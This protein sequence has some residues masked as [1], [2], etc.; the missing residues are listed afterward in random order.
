MSTIIVVMFHHICE[1]LRCIHKSE[2]KY[3]KRTSKLTRQDIINTH[4][5]TLVVYDPQS[6]L[7]VRVKKIITKDETRLN[8]AQLTMIPLNLNTIQPRL[9]QVWNFDEI[10]IDMNGTQ[11]K[12]ICTYNRC[13]TQQYGKHKQVSE[14]RFGSHS[15]FSPGQI[16]S[17]LAPSCR[18]PICRTER[19][20]DVRYPKQLDFIC[21]NKQ[22]HGQ[23]RLM[24]GNKLLF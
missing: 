9:S 24:E 23:R 10:V 1:M 16:G 4:I 19:R 14:H 8:M 21:N 13:A 5:T 6:S 20:L 2:M 11:Y 18:T 22:L 3:N 12:I 15:Y 17:I 7:V